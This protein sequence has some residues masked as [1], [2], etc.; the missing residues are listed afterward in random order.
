[1]MNFRK[2]VL[3]G[4][5][6]LCFVSFAFPANALICELWDI[7]NALVTPLPVNDSATNVNT[8]MTQLQQ[9]LQ[10]VES[11]NEKDA[12]INKV[13]KLASGNDTLSAFISQ[14]PVP[15]IENATSGATGLIDAFKGKLEGVGSVVNFEKA[16]QIKNALNKAAVVSNPIDDVERLAEDE[17]KRAFIQQTKIEL[18]A[19]VLVLKKKLAE[20]KQADTQAQNSS[21]SQDTNGIMNLAIRMK[22]FENQVQILEQDLAAKHNV[23]ESIRLLQ[24]ADPVLEE[25]PVGGKS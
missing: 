24:E 13:K 6:S 5:C 22:D 19:D 1:M 10:T 23:L 17:K 12:Y 15:Q 20:L 14:V 25:I 21:S 7:L 18:L 16:D 11:T 3:I 2:K 4:L 9:I 8:L